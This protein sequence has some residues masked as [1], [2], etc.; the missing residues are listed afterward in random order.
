MYS[1]S[2]FMVKDGVVKKLIRFDSDLRF[3]RHFSIA[4]KYLMIRR[5]RLR[6]ETYDGGQYVNH[7]TRFLNFLN[8]YK[9][10]FFETDAD[11]ITLDD[12]QDF[13][14]VITH[15]ICRT[16]SEP[17]TSTMKCYRH[18]ITKFLINLKDYSVCTELNKHYLMR[19]DEYTNR[20][21]YELELDKK[22]ENHKNQIVIRDCPEF[23]VDALL[24][25]ARKYDPEVYILVALS[26]YAGLR[27]SEACN[28]RMLD[29]IYGP[30]YEFVSVIDEGEIETMS[31][32]LKLDVMAHKRMLRQDHVKVGG[33]KSPRVVDVYGPFLE[34]LLNAINEYLQYTKDRKREITKP[35]V[36][37][38]YKTGGYHKAM[39][40][41][42]YHRRFKR[43]CNQYVFPY[44]AKQGVMQE[45][46]VQKLKSG[47]YGPHMLRE[48]FTCRLVKEGVK[49]AQIMTYRGDKNT[50]SAVIY[51][52]KGGAFEDSILNTQRMICE[53]IHANGEKLDKI[54]DTVFPI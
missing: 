2:K 43:L 13:L 10:I 40:Y 21:V 5:N 33:I 24:E 31:L 35:L 23:F 36:V 26:I 37:G 38:K 19:V 46:Y 22:T 25:M 45:W 17:K 48:Y 30:G 47:K 29:S 12:A 54:R 51:V 49:W 32:C 8:E 42:N 6:N 50:Q 39:T 1:V 18:N 15:E 4:N 9:G 52:L 28:M 7:V 16:G 34:K 11:R 20:T 3:V 44:L 27:P 53:E 41:N 14:D